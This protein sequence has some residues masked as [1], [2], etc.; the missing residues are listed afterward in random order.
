MRGPAF[1]KDFERGVSIVLFAETF[2][3]RHQGDVV[4]TFD[5]EMSDSR[6]VET[7]LELE[8]RFQFSEFFPPEHKVP[9]GDYGWIVTRFTPDNH[10]G[11]VHSG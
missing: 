5:F 8:C 10:Q 2:Y 4:D 11:E 1:W 9:E 6:E 3:Y 7:S